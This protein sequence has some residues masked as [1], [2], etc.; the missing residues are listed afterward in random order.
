VQPA[1]LARGLRRVAIERGVRLF[2]R[3]PMRRLERTRPPLVRTDSG[4]VRAERVVLALNAW[5][6]ALPE[7]RRSLVVVTSDVIATPPIPERLRDIDWPDGVGISDSR[8]MVNYWRSTHDG[9]IVFGRGAGG[10]AYGARI[11]TR[12][13]GPTPRAGWVLDSFHRLYP[14][15]GDVTAESSWRGPI[16]RSKVGLPFFG[17]L[18]GHDPILVGA[19]YSGNGVGP[20]Y[21]GG[22]ILA[23]LTLGLDDQW[24]AS[25]LVRRPGGLP[26]EPARYLGG[27]GVR[28]AVARKE[29]TEDAGREPRRL[30]LFLAG[31]AP[32]ALVPL[33]QR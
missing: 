19:G 9:R 15:L 13:D 26:P 28:A 23:S 27:R 4:S 8:L 24:A 3:S 18:G 29:L 25:G 2:E 30:D 21:L 17:P 6:A 31:L 7:L 16:D 22:R 14:S 1:S 32:A 10:L 12:Y 20:S 33:K 11:G 5:V